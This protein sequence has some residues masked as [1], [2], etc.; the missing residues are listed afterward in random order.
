MGIKTTITCDIDG[1]TIDGGFER[2]GTGKR[3]LIICNDHWISDPE[4]VKALISGDT[5]EFVDEKKA[6]KDAVIAAAVAAE[7]AAEAAAA[8][9]AAAESAEADE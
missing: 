7:A 2:F 8:E 3:E 4:G 5:D 1:A 6:Q 9:K